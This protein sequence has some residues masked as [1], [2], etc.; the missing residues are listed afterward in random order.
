MTV[1]K[2]KPGSHK[3]YWNKFIKEVVTKI[4]QTNPCVFML[5]GDNAS[6]YIKCIVKESNFILT[7]R[8][9]TN[10]NFLG[11]DRFSSCNEILEAM[12]YATIKW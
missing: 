9:P 1:E 8:G 5:W 2:D 10:E 6:K 3:K 12:G 7:S 4:S 11:S